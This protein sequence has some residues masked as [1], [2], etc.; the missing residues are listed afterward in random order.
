MVTQR[1]PFEEYLQ[2]YQAIE[3]SGGEYMKVMIELE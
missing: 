2:A 3:T 1:F